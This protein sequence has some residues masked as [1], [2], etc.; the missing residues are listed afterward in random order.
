MNLHYDEPHQLLAMW[1][2]DGFNHQ[3]LR[4]MGK[5]CQHLE[6]FD[7]DL[8]IYESICVQGIQIRCPNDSWFKA[9]SAGHA[10]QIGA[11]K[12]EFP[13]DFP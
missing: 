8:Q 7:H 5:P 2:L 13:L 9:K 11:A 1:I 12:L 3:P 10:D 4:S 6:K